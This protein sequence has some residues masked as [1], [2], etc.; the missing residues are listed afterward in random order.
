MN[1]T[2]LMLALAAAAIQS[3]RARSAPQ[4]APPTEKAEA[5]A[6][7]VEAVSIKLA[8][9]A[10][11]LL[12]R[13][14]APSPR[15]TGP[16]AGGRKPGS[17]VSMTRKDGKTTII[18]SGTPEGDKAEAEAKAKPDGVRALPEGVESIM[19]DDATGQLQARGTAAGI[20][21]LRAIVAFL[22]VPIRKV[23]LQV[24]AVRVNKVDL[25][26][27]GLNWAQPEGTLSPGFL[28]RADYREALQKLL[29][30]NLALTLLDVRAVTVNNIPGAFSSGSF[31]GQPSILP[32]VELQLV[33][34]INN[35][36]TITL[37][38]DSAARVPGSRAPEPRAKVRTV[39]NVRDGDTFVLWAPD[40]DRESKQATVSFITARLV[41]RAGEKK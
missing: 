6:E 4:A 35:D 40:A 39:A 7:P 34:T 16:A 3:P 2:I 9:V 37:V 33:P 41:R 12:A 21:K 38:A 28:H 30:A 18:R 24:L 11:S 14:I 17:I 20:E 26:G 27:L 1:K 36:D 29:D 23:E 8:H 19:P 5:Q 25:K 22:D 31:D 32:T 10:P 13:M 15:S